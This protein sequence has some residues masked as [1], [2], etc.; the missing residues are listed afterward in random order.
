MAKDSPEHSVPGHT[1]QASFHFPPS[2]KTNAAT[3][4]KG[5]RMDTQG[6]WRPT[7]EDNVS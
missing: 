4:Q 6:S 2:I 3:N 5:T 7:M 1:S